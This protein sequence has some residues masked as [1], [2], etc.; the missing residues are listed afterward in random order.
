MSITPV[1]GTPGATLSG[2]RTRS[3]TAGAAVF[4]DLRINLT[5][6]LYR[7]RATA[8]SLAEDSAPFDVLL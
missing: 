2:T 1:T 3:V 6:L 5:G 4:D 8:G 7:L